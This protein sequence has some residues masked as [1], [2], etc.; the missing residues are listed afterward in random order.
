MPEITKN[1]LSISQMIDNGYEVVFKQSSCIIHDRAVRKIVE[2]QMVK[3]SFH[4]KLSSVEEAT[5]LAQYEKEKLQH[6]K[7]VQTED[8]NL[9][10]LQPNKQRFMVLESKPNN[11]QS[12]TYKEKIEKDLETKIKHVKY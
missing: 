1:L 10:M 6:Q 12:C 11:Q 8:S 3:N 9:R 2:L 7:V 4:L 5:M